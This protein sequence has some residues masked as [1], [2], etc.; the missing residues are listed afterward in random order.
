[1]SVLWKCDICGRD[2]LVHPPTELVYK[3][4]ESKEEKT[5]KKI[6]TK[7][8]EIIKVKQQD[9]HSG[10]MKEIEVN[11]RRDL[12][13]RTYIVKLSIGPESI[14]KDLCL[15]CLNKI[16]EPLIKAFNTLEKVES[17]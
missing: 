10:K 5:G 6:I 9:P 17:K 14:Q 12:F 3:E 8:P 13:P 16:K 7:I 15:E 4:I 1:M 2:T 11:K